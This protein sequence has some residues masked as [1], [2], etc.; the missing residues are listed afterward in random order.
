MRFMSQD[1]C[2]PTEAATPQDTDC[3]RAINAAYDKGIDTELSAEQNAG[4]I[5]LLKYQCIFL[6]AWK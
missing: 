2:F 3:M 6:G 5:R 1:V 4:L